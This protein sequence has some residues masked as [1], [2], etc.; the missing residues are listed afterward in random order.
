MN[1]KIELDYQESEALQRIIGLAKHL[2]ATRLLSEDDLYQLDI[3]VLS[4]L[5]QAWGI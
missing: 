3:G 4:K 2:V 5:R 1:I